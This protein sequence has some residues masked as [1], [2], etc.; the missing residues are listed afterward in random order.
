MIIVLGQV[1]TCRH[2][3]ARRLQRNC[4]LKSVSSTSPI[5]FLQYY[6]WKCRITNVPAM[7]Q[8]SEGIH[9]CVLMIEISMP[10]H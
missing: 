7:V 8:R 3:K 10:V 4:C 1:E 6:H 9:D 5:M 2:R